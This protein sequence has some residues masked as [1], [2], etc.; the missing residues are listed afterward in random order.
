MKETARIARKNA[1]ILFQKNTIISDQYRNRVPA[2]KDYFTCFAY[3]DTHNTSETGNE[4]I[5]EEQ[6]ITFDTRWC[7]ELAAVTSTEY[8]IIF[9]GEHYNIR[10]VDMMNYQGRAIRFFCR[11]ETHQR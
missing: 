5:T 3:A 9:N 2:W 1:R 4:V 7:P 8:R 6:S 10:S 11:R